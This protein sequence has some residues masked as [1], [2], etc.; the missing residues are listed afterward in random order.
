MITS[1]LATRIE[2]S[3]NFR[4]R[5]DGEELRYIVIHGT[6]M[7]DDAAV[8]RRLMDPITKVSAHYFIDHAGQIIQL[9]GEDNVAWHAGK[10]TWD[11]LDGLN[12]YSIGI[13]VGNAGPFAKPP[14]P[15]EEA[16]PDWA[17]APP[18]RDCQYEALAKL[19]ADIRTRHP[20]ITAKRILGH[21]DISPGRKSDPGPHFEWSRLGLRRGEL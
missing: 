10:S 15:D 20:Q 17:K 12:S 14:T 8:I 19:I 11:G 4:E 18:Y 16:N 21:S 2:L 7:A 13:E 1:P 5:K 9:V 3:P 6:W